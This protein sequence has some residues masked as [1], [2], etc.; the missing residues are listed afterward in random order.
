VVSCSPKGPYSGNNSK[1]V[2]LLLNGVGGD[3]VTTT[4]TGGPP[5]KSN[6]NHSTAQGLTPLTLA[7]QTN[8]IEAVRLLVSANANILH[9]C[10]MGFSP[11]VWGL[12]GSLSAPP[13]DPEADSEQCVKFLLNVAANRGSSAHNECQ[14][15]YNAFKFS[16]LLA[17]LRETRS[18]QRESESGS[19]KADDLELLSKLLAALPLNQS[20]TDEAAAALNINMCMLEKIHSALEGTL[21]DAFSR[22]WTLPKADAQAEALLATLTE[23]QVMN[24]CVSQAPASARCQLRVM[25]T[26]PYGPGGRADKPP[27]LVPY[28]QAFH[29]DI[30][31]E[32]AN[33]ETQSSGFKS[34]SYVSGLYKDY[35]ELIVDLCANRYSAAIPT[36]RG[37]DMVVEQLRRA[38]SGGHVLTQ[39]VFDPVSSEKLATDDHELA[40]YWADLIS[41]TDHPDVDIDVKYYN[42]ATDTHPATGDVLVVAPDL[43]WAGQKNSFVHNV[44]TSLQTLIENK[45]DGGLVIVVGECHSVAAG[46]ASVQAPA[47]SVNDGDDDDEM[48]ELADAPVGQNHESGGA[49]SEELST[50]FKLAVGDLFE[51]GLRILTSKNYEIKARQPLPNWLHE[52]CEIVVWGAKN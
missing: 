6:P 23:Q 45:N 24:V 10:A 20:T 34:P 22:I 50:P 46:A 26:G 2:E 51:Q 1:M 19:E 13:A 48:P 42:L 17:T 11:I 41:G 14:Q 15:D 28:K 32:P 4:V 16:K 29:A 12:I 52:K 18:R 27:F 8:D 7:M 43:L 33:Q 38:N 37:L 47:A 25:M 44:F 21:P 39:I 40:S 31:A 3:D 36:Q 49:S 30:H 9:R 5:N 35:K